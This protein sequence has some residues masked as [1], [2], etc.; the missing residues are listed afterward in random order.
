MS[1]I[2]SRTKID[3][4]HAAVNHGHF[5]GLFVTRHVQNNSAVVLGN[6]HNKRGIADFITQHVLVTMQIR[7]MSD[8]AVRDS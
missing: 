5:C 8:K 7:A 3:R 1:R 2:V 6:C 4:I